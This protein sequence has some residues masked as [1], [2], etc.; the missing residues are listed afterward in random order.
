LQNAL[1]TR[2]SGLVVDLAA[3]KEQQMAILLKHKPLAADCQ[4]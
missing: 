4:L 3:L 1:L 2:P